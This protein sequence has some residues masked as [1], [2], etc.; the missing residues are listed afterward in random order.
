M[1]GLFVLSQSIL[2]VE[3]INVAVM[4]E[5]KSIS[6]KQGQKFY[7]KKGDIIKTDFTGTATVKLKR[8]KI[9]IKPNSC[10]KWNNDVECSVLR[11]LVFYTGKLTKK[12][13]RRFYLPAY[14]VGVRGTAFKLAVSSTSSGAIVMKKGKVHLLTPSGEVKVIKAGQRYFLPVGPKASPEELK[15]TVESWLSYENERAN[16]NPR[17]A[18]L[19]LYKK[20]EYIE[21]LIKSPA[22]KRLPLSKRVAIKSALQAAR[23]SIILNAEAF[24]E[25]F[26]DLERINQIF[27]EI[28]MKEEAFDR[29]IELLEKEGEETEEMLEKEF[30]MFEKWL[31]EE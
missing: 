1:M 9:K 19:D 15:Q 26:G 5:G 28:K 30:E 6:L 4:R 13:F 8:E 22:F 12:G 11:G 20:M 14:A 24:K 31:E 27:G 16:K 3:H 7:L 18:M 10:I 21:K 17:Q 23:L 25:A 29:D 2:T